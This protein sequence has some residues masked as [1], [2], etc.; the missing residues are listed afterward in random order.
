MSAQND[1]FLR[2]LE[3]VNA[4]IAHRSTHLASLP[5]TSTPQLV[6][7]AIDTLPTSL[8]ETGLGL[9]A[10]TTLLLDTVAPALAGGQ[11]G[12][13][14]Y[15]LVIGGVLPEAQLADQLVTSFDPNIQVHFPEESAAYILERKALD[16]LLS[17]LS[18]PPKLFT[19]N[20]FT[21]GATASNLLGLVLGREHSIA[22]VQRHRGVASP[23]GLSEWSVAEDGFGG[24]DVDVFHAGAH[25]SVTKTA[26]LAG[27]GRR[28]VHDLT[29]LEDASQP[30]AFNLEQLEERL[31]ANVGKRGSVVVSSFGEVNS[32][33]ITP[34]SERIRELCDQYNA[35]LHCD[36]AFGAFA[37]LHPDFAHL[38]RQLALSDSITGDA[39]KWLNVPYDC[40]LFFSR[41]SFL[42]ATCG[43]GQ[44]SAAYLS[45]APS[46]TTASQFP[47][48]DPY[49][50][51]PSSL[52]LT[53]ENSKRFR[54]LPVLAGLLA[55][56]R[57]GY[58]S[59]FA[60]NI[61]FVRKVELWMRDGGVGGA[62]EVLTPLSS[63]AREEDFRTMNIVLFGLAQSGP[64]RFRGEGGAKL[65][66]KEVNE[67]RKVYL[68]A[69]SWRGRGAVRVA[70]SNWSTELERDFDVLVE[71]L[72]EVIMA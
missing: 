60:R 67:R 16:M 52:F 26:S 70:V 30:C 49:R 1:E 58:A 15:G 69:T 39:H 36:A 7:N 34:F 10:T 66:A 20:T 25:A 27:I 43:P 5:T 56:G 63:T 9:E 48:I 11:A 33:G 42:Y 31:K 41:S 59:L 6:S 64:E 62:F 2:Q 57:D 45:S 3:R 24:I 38:S 50:D 54:G 29:D 8:P 65:F 32:G 46:L 71:A 23:S 37:A 12:P 47:S 18:L 55:Q 13:H 44:T 53:I 35:W 61:A 72:E 21:T 17:L 4:A 22:R 28:N 40:G 68:T 14:Y 51:L 19:A